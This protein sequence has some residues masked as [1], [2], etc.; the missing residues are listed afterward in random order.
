[1]FASAPRRFNARSFHSYLIKLMF[2]KV[3]LWRKMKQQK[4]I[5]VESNVSFC[6]VFPSGGYFKI[7]DV[8]ANCFKDALVKVNR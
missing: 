7:K 8:Y 6:I 1:M 5:G 4:K 3:F 2:F